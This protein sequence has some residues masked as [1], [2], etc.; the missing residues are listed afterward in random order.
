MDGEN[1]ERTVQMKR[2][3]GELGSIRDTN[4][5]IEVMRN[6]KVKTLTY[7][8]EVWKRNKVEQSQVQLT[9]MNALKA[10]AKVI[11][12]TK[13]YTGHL[14]WHRR[15]WFQ[16]MRRLSEETVKKRLYHSDEMGKVGRSR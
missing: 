9:E 6:L 3:I 8:S 1:I 10:A 11:R 12:E 14:E 13:K 16:Q 5:S 2:A 7:G 4:M 15:P